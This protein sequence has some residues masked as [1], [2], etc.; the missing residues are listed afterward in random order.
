[1]TRTS[2]RT[3]LAPLLALTLTLAIGATLFAQPASDRSP[4]EKPLTR[5][6]L[7]QR[8]KTLQQEQARLRAALDRLNG[9]QASP[10]N[11]AGLDHRAGR[12]DRFATQRRSDAPPIALTD[13]ARQRAIKVLQAVNPELFNRWQKLNETNPQRAEQM[14]DRLIE[15]MQKN[16]Q[17]REM[18]ALLDKNPELF[19]I[20]AQQFALERRAY[21]AARH[22]VEATATGD[23]TAADEAR[24]KVR[25][26]IEQQID[27]RFKEQHLTLAHSEQRLKNLRAEIEKQSSR[28][29][30]LV[31][32]RVEQVIRR[33]M[34]Q[35]QPFKSSA[36]QRDGRSQSNHRNR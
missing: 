28:R 29:D 19:Q 27:Q 23:Q 7:E 33:A 31:D 16:P 5:Q 22:F 3:I 24:A 35:K 21:F 25:S 17:V 20:R 34:S 18:L 26:L 30:T 4:D 15:R 2:A 9:E 11:R 8:L 32:Q 13:E 14:R 6:R 36:S 12:E 1:M 10:L